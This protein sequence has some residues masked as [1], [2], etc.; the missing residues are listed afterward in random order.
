MHKILVV[1]DDRATRKALQQLFEGEGFQV[2]LAQNG[3]EG[4]ACFHAAKPNFVILD[5][6]MPQMSGQDACR[7]IR[8]ESEEVPII[9]LTGSAD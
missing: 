6:K 7:Q 3:A 8:K 4:V 2:E 5:L 1:E 9:I